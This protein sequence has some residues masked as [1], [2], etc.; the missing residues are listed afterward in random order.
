MQ[1]EISH[2]NQNQD[3]VACNKK[4]VLFISSAL[5]P[6]N[7]PDES[8]V[9]DYFV[10][11]AAK[12]SI[13]LR[14][15]QY[16]V[17]L[18]VPHR[19]SS[20]AVDQKR[21]L[22]ELNNI[23]LNENYSGIII[24]PFDTDT[25]CDSLATLM[26][27]NNCLLPPVPIL[28]I[29][30]YIKRFTNGLTN[31]PPPHHVVGNWKKGGELAAQSIMHYFTHNKAAFKKGTT[32]NIAILKGLQGS[33]ERIK[34]FTKEIQKAKDPHLKFKIKTTLEG[35]FNRSVSRNVV[36]ENYQKLFCQDDE[37]KNINAFFCCNDEMALGV[38]DVLHEQNDILLESIN[39][40][41]TN[42][43]KNDIKKRKIKLHNIKIVGFDGISES[44]FLVNN[45]DKWLIN[46]VDVQV[47]NQVKHLAGLFK[48]S[49]D[50]KKVTPITTDV[51]LINPI[52]NQYNTYF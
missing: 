2:I 45:K 13:E 21:F 20:A 42:I 17:I 10:V 4:P 41:R 25:I 16:E 12:L 15:L 18:M 19:Q 8:K 11:I 33:D 6:D 27:K 29:D 31:T 5:S 34:S 37:K 23:K 24:A 22:D 35:N 48:D 9:F 14:H 26:S 30:K 39:D 1:V 7:H 46:S 49:I 32:I 50:G 36:T 3:S 28:T 51:K 40:S 43:R 44:R 52:Q 38:R 47:F